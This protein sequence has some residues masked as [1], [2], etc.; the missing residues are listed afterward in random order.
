MKITQEKLDNYI[1]RITEVTASI[2]KLYDDLN[3]VL[4]NEKKEQE[5]KEYLNLA[6]LVE[7]KI[8]E[9]IGDDILQEDRFFRRLSYLIHRSDL[10]DKN[11]VENRIVNYIVQK[12]YANPFLSRERYKSA[13]NEENITIIRA[14]ATMDYIKAILLTLDE[15][16]KKVPNK[17]TKKR[18]EKSKNYTIFANK[19]VAMILKSERKHEIN[20][21]NRCIIFN[22]DKSQVKNIYLNYASEI[23]NYCFYTILS[24]D[25]NI[26]EQ[27]QLK[28][29]LKLL[30]QEE[31]S[32]VAWQYHQA[33]SSNKD[34]QVLANNN[35]NNEIIINI[36]REFLNKKEKLS[37]KK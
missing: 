19:F 15:E 9:E 5:I 6:L 28:S 26:F 20:G 18:L 30:T 16:I 10:K 17:T 7:D 25:D 2:K 31:I 35:P 13:Y 29:S 3:K 36:I 22:H 32:L 33:I 4:G 14:Q 1:T 11:L 12:T 37:T 8:Y 34:F 21:R 24:K 23:I 27:I